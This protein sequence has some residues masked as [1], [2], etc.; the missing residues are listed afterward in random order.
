MSDEL[1][2]FY[3]RELS[4]L[5]QAG[6]AFADEYPRVA[7]NLRISSDTVEDPH[8]SRLIE[9]VA[10]LNAGVQKKIEDEFPEVVTALLEH[11]YPHYLAPLPSML[12]AEFVPSPGI[13][14]QEMIQRHTR[15]EAPLADGVACQFQTVLPVVLSPY[16]LVK[17]QLIPKPFTVPGSERMGRASAVLHLQLACDNKE[18][19][20]SSCAEGLLLHIRPQ[21]Q[22]VWPLYD[23]F[24]THCVGICVADSD[25]DPHPVFI[26]PVHLQP[27]GFGR[28]EGL[29]P[30]PDH[31]ESPYRIL[32]EFFALPEKFLFFRLG[33]LDTISVPKSGEVNLY[34]FFD[35]TGRDIERSLNETTFSLSASPVINLFSQVAEPVILQDDQV[36]YQLVPDNRTHEHMEVYAV[37]SAVLVNERT[38]EHEPVDPYFGF[39]HKKQGSGLFWHGIRRDAIGLGSKTD[40]F[41][42]VSDLDKKRSY[43]NGIALQVEAL[44]FN[45]NL[46][47]KL[48]Y[49]GG[50][51]KF[52][53]ITP[54]NNVTEI[55]SVYPP[56]P[57]RRIDLRHGLLWRLLSHL[58][59]NYMGLAGHAQPGEALREI[60]RLYDFGDSAV[61]RALIDAVENVHVDITAMPIK[62]GGRSVVCRGMD[63]TVLFSD[64]VFASSSPLLYGA[65]LD[66]FFAQYVNINSFTRL[67]VRIKGRDDIFHRWP[68]RTGARILI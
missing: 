8:V 48:P 63:I 30:Y 59:I 2:E 40:Y 34:L 52:S 38:G 24:H 43:T 33:G 54:I 47:S 3:E 45:G 66:I 58:N 68:P 41:I 39:T 22:H 60:L 67:S 31:T 13:D 51:P 15:I 61:T 25:L 46:P 55:R 64:T 56:T 14:K 4:W 10:L 11:L 57:V 44:C 6:S 37:Q 65:V 17:A 18:F 53:A 19:L 20:L 27:V 49:G 12:I 7:G 28:D 23:L 1:L 62:A 16:T 35:A 29:L 5:K 9:S 21:Y 26:D 36:E 50:Q 32:T 42:S